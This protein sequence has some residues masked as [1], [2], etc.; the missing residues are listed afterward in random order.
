MKWIEYCW[1]RARTADEQRLAARAADAAG[2]SAPPSATGLCLGDTS[3]KDNGSSSGTAAASGSASGTELV[4]SPRRR[5]AREKEK[6]SVK[7][8]RVVLSPA[9]YVILVLLAVMVVMIFVDIMPIAGLICVFAIIMVVTVVLGNRWQNREVWVEE[10]GVQHPIHYYHLPHHSETASEQQRVR[11]KR[12][13]KV[14]SVQLKGAHHH[15]ADGVS[16]AAAE[17]EPQDIEAMPLTSQQL[18]DRTKADDMSSTAAQRASSRRNSRSSLERHSDKRQSSA[19]ASGNTVVVQEENELGPLT[20]EDYLDNLN[21]FFEELF[22][23]ID[24][25]LLIIFLGLFIVVENMAD[26]GIPKYVW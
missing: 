24:Y 16:G 10:Q 13:S 2:E 18:S 15:G 23:S 6:L 25:S 12:Q 4:L 26:T 1:L 17:D 8:A 5:R 22:N 9:P 11:S 20:R 19:A 14:R 21:Q 7:A 3:A